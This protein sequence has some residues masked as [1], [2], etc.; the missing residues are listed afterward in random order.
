MYIS[1]LV[2]KYNHQNEGDKLI[3]ISKNLSKKLI[4]ENKKLNE[5]NHTLDP[6]HNQF[7]WFKIFWQ[8]MLKDNQTRHQHK[9]LGRKFIGSWAN[10]CIK[11]L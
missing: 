8:K 4:E 5:S 11:F 6:L 10:K 2:C 1:K 7:W 9:L 3:L